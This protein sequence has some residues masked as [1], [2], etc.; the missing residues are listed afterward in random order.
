M[1][2][3]PD[4]I[5]IARERAR[6]R[7]GEPRNGTAPRRI[8]PPEEYPEDQRGDAW[9]PPAEPEYSGDHRTDPEQRTGYDIILD[10]FREKYGPTFRRGNVLCSVGGREIRANEACFAPSA[11]LIERLRAAS[12]APR[13][14]GQV[15]RSALP[16]FFVTWAKVAWVDLLDGLPEEEDAEEVAALATEAFKDRVAKALLMHV[17]LGFTRQD[18]P[19]EVTNQERRPLLDW[20]ARFAV[21]GKWADVRGYRIWA[22]RDGGRLRIAVRAELFAQLHIADL[23]RLSK[24]KFAKLAARYDVGTPARVAGQ[25]VV[26]LSELF[27][28]EL[29]GG[30]NPADDG[31][32]DGQSSGALSREAQKCPSVTGEVNS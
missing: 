10:Y 1:T 29:L 26:E 25:R 5:R 11:E 8:P 20:C 28:A 9:E 14:E 17:T 2:C 3:E 4:H 19:A 24:T 27:L 15:K 16:R 31:L 23:A 22:C 32:T 13:E 21:E 6:Q 18:G 30:E 7:L 12:D